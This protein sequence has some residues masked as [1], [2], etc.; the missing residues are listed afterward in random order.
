M[1]CFFI[2]RCLCKP[3]AF[4]VYK[5]DLCQRVKCAIIYHRLIMRSTVVV[6]IFNR[7]AIY[8]A[9]F[10]SDKM[11]TKVFFREI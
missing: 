2:N 8:S 6:I 1:W 3:D 9:F 10:I 4:I 7:L 11:L 5:V